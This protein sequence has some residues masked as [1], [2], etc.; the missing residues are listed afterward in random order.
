MEGKA[1]FREF[2]FPF[3][4]VS[5]PRWCTGLN[6]DGML[7]ESSFSVGFWVREIEDYHQ[8]FTPSYCSS[9]HERA[10]HQT[11]GSKFDRTCVPTVPVAVLFRSS[12][13]LTSPTQQQASTLLSTRP[14]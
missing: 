12:R 8:S 2:S 5:N 14:Y 9:T 13:R 1:P 10:N 3:P 7:S 4:A 11:P 6:Q